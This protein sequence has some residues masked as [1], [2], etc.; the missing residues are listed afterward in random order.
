MSRYVDIGALTR[1]V[2]TSVEVGSEKTASDSESNLKTDIGIAIKQAAENIRDYEDT[3]VTSADLKTVVQG[4]K[5]AVF[6]GSTTGAQMAG[7]MAGSAGG[8]LA[9]GAAGAAAGSLLG[10]VG[11]LVGGAYG[12]MKGMG[13]GG[14]VGS[15]VAQGAANMTQ[16]GA[17]QP[18]AR[19]GQMRTASALGDELRKLAT[20]IREQG[21]NNEEIRLTKAAQMLTA[22]VGLGH[23]TEGLS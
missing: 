2:L 19:P 11:S 12:A 1:D 8:A 9:G 22:A 13:T 23:L 17:V 4:A 3:N 15:N 18:T 16:T 14:A 7:G 10:P 6:G 20:Q 5:L 21:A